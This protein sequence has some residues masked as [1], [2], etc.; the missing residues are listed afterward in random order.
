LLAARGSGPEVVRLA[1]PRRRWTDRDE[2]VAF[3]RRQLWTTSGSAAD[4][5]LLAA[6]DDLAVVAAD[7]TVALSRTPALD[8][9][10]VTWSLAESC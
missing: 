8:V 5:R 9:G 1:T 3:L 7:G 2:L 4:A 6:V 10:I